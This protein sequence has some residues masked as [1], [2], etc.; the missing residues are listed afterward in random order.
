MPCIHP[1]AMGHPISGSDPVSIYNLAIHGGHTLQTDDPAAARAFAKRHGHRLTTPGTSK[2]WAS[3]PSLTPPPVARRKET[4]DAYLAQIRKIVQM[5]VDDPATWIGEQFGRAVDGWA[6]VAT[7]GHRL[8]ATRADVDTDPP[9]DARVRKLI[10][11]PNKVIG[12]GIMIPDRIGERLARLQ[13]FCNSRPGA[14]PMGVEIVVAD[15]YL[16]FNIG[17]DEDGD[18]A[19]E[20]V[21][22]VGC[23]GSARLLVNH[24]Y[25]SDAIGLPAV[26]YVPVTDTESLVVALADDTIRH[27]LM[28]MRY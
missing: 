12:G 4:P 8:I 2:R 23:E 10:R 27:I 18:T 28:P 25:L 11:L 16:H 5:P 7:D 22:H 21:C 13:P 14:P 17:P 1:G 6:L 3:L 20:A 15:G 24:Q 9:L 26:W 19:S